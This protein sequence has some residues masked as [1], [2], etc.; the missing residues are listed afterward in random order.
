M[1]V[2]KVILKCMWKFKGARIANIIMGGGE[3]LEDVTLQGLL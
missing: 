2:E 3:K 1:D